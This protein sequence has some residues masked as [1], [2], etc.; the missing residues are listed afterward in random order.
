MDYITVS[1]QFRDQKSFKTVPNYVYK[2]QGK[3]NIQKELEFLSP[4]EWLISNYIWNFYFFPK[5]E[6]HMRNV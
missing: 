6:I 5:T 3:K 1:S 2:F 4:L